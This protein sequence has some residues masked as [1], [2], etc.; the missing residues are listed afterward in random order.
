MLQFNVTDLNNTVKYLASVY[1]SEGDNYYYPRKSKILLGKTEED[2][3]RNARLVSNLCQIF[4][5]NHV[6]QHE[7][8]TT[9]AKTRKFGNNSDADWNFIV[10][11]ILETLMVF[12][13]SNVQITDKLQEFFTNY[14]HLLKYDETYQ[15]I[16]L[17]TLGLDIG[18][19]CIIL[20]EFFRLKFINSL[21]LIFDGSENIQT[22]KFESI[23]FEKRLGIEYLEL[24]EELA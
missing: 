21:D 1:S 6:S 20:N 9:Y 14:H 24:T 22:R 13:E 10:L 2:A 3:L 5:Q 18:H 7:I 8:E 16:S 15:D 19:I 23:S 4:I 17:N 11:M 12:Q